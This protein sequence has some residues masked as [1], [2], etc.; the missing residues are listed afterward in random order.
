MQRPASVLGVYSG[1]TSG[2]FWQLDARQLKEANCGTERST[3]FTAQRLAANH[4]PFIAVQ[5]QR[6]GTRPPRAQ[7]TPALC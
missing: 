5:E 2:L 1:R 3:R 7:T 4:G 6:K